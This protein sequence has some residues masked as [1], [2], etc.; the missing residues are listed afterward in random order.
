MLLFKATKF[1]SDHKA[2]AASGYTYVR[3]SVPGVVPTRG[4][5]GWLTE[6]L[7]ASVPFP[8]APSFTGLHL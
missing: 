1:E 5:F 6:H 4:T 7:A 3:Q 8:E 2:A